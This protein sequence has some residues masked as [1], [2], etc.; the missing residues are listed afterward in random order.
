[1]TAAV[2]LTNNVVLIYL[3]K[4]DAAFVRLIESHGASQRFWQAI[5]LI[6]CQTHQL[7]IHQ[8]CVSGKMTD[9]TPARK[10]V[11]VLESPKAMLS[12][13]KTTFKDPSNAAQGEVNEKPSIAQ[14]LPCNNEAKWHAHRQAPVGLSLAFV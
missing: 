11:C 2:K 5:D 8:F 13:P 6:R 12:T 14:D 9:L 1:M 4:A 3:V 7:V 10:C